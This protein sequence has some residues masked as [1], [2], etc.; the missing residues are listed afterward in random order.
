MTTRGNLIAVG[1]LA[2]DV[3]LWD[4][5]GAKLATVRPGN[6]QVHS[7]SIRDR[8]L[9]VVT[10]T[11]AYEY[12]ID[13]ENHPTPVFLKPIERLDKLGVTTWGSYSSNGESIL[14][15][16]T[17]NF[18]EQQALESYRPALHLSLVDY[19]NVIR[20]LSCRHAR[21][22][23]AAIVIEKLQLGKMIQIRAVRVTPQEEINSLWSDRDRLYWT[24]SGKILGWWTFHLDFV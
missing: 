13:L 19:D 16:K 8:R 22:E 23:Q 10:R 1:S 17:G 15:Q 4:Y 18:E 14:C 5:T 3:G 7:L 9:L 20:I 6:S 11:E 2:G 21:D 12:G 24:S